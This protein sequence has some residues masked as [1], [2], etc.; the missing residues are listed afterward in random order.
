M[1]ILIIYGTSEGQTRKIARFMEDVLQEV[2]HKVVIA[3]STEEP[4][5][6]DAYEMV[7]IG[8][9][10]HMHK[11]K[12][13]IRSYIMENV[14]ELNKKQTAFF[15]VCMAVASDVEEE[16]KD[17]DEI[18][19]TFLEQAA[20]K[21]KEIVQIAGALRFTKYDYFKRLI[22]RMIANKKG[23]VV[24]TSKDYEYT[25]WKAVEKFVLEFVNINK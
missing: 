6:P 21:P 17:A 11:Y 2:G 9:S 1:K 14:E 4:P 24:D 3:D 12:N 10:I 19:R 25:D 7:L 15:S 20:W 13:S 16:R 8:S 22:M 23:E 18:A 5:A